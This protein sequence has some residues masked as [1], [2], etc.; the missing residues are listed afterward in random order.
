MLVD[1]SSV[2]SLAHT[3][4]LQSFS[5]LYDYLPCVEGPLVGDSVR[6]MWVK[7]HV[8]IKEAYS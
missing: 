8:C 5:H 3:V 6:H 7:L 1:I 2:C 4:L